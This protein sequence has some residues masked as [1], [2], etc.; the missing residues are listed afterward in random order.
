MKKRSVL[1]LFLLLLTLALFGASAAAT[2]GVVPVVGYT[3]VKSATVLTTGQ[4]VTYTLDTYHSNITDN[5][6]WVAVNVERGDQAIEMTF[7]DIT[8]S[9]YAYIYRAATVDSGI[10]GNNY[11]GFVSFKE[12][13]TWRWKADAAG[14]YYIA[15]R[16]QSSSYTA[17]IPSYLTCTLLDGDLNESNDT[18]LTATE[19]TENVST[20]YN[21]N[22]WNDVDWFK[23]TTT[24]PGEAIKLQF[25]NFDYTVANINAYLYTEAGLQAGSTSAAWSETNF[26][27]NGSYNYKANIPGNYYLK[28]QSYNNAASVTKDLKISYTT[29]A[30]DSYE[31][32][33]T[34]GT[35]TKMSYSYPMEFT[36]NGLN[37]VDW[38][39]FETSQP[40]EL[41]YLN[42]SGFDLD[43]TNHI[44]Y[45]IYEPTLDGL[46][47]SALYYV[48]NVNMTYTAAM[49]FANTGPHYIKISRYSGTAV[50]NTL[51]LTLVQ[52]TTDA[53]EPNDTWQTSTPMAENTDISFNIPSNSD[54]DW[55]KFSTTEPDQTLDLT[56]WLPSGGGAWVHLYSGADLENSGS[57]AS[58]LKYCAIYSGTSNVRWMLSDVGDYYIKVSHRQGVFEETATIKYTLIA[59]DANERNNSWSTAVT[60]NQNVTT[61]YTLPAENDYEW[62]KFTTTVPDVTLDLTTWVPSG[63]G[64]W[65]YLYSGA[66][67]QTSGSGAAS[68]KYWA[69][70]SG[71]SNMRWMLREAGEY[72]IQISARGGNIFDEKGSITYDL[73]AP[74]AHERNNSWQ[75]AK[76]MNEG[77][78]TSF[79]LPA[80][81]DSDWFKFTTAA[82]HQTV[83]INCDIP[84]GGGAWIYVYSGAD[85]QT[86]GSGA[87]SMKYWAV[88]S[89]TSTFRWMLQEAGEYYIQV[90][91]RGSYFDESASIA[92]GLINA[93]SHE[94]NNNYETATKL[95]KG[96]ALYFTLPA[97]N[98]YDYFLLGEM[99]A[100]DILQLTYGGLNPN[101]VLYTDVYVLTEGSTSLTHVKDTRI[102]ASGSGKPNTITL[103]TD[104]TYYVALEHGTPSDS[105]MWVRYAVTAADKPVEGISSI[106][107]GDSTIFQGKTLQLY[108]NITPTNATN[109][110]V[111]WSSSKTSVATVDE[112]GMVTGV[113]PGSATITATTVDGG[114]RATTT[115]TVADPV[116]VTGVTVTA[117]DVAQKGETEKNPYYLALGTNVALTATVLPETATEQAVIWSVSNDDIL[118]VN[119]YGQVYAIGS[120]SATV[121]ATTVDG[122]YTATFYVNI[123]DETY[124]VKGIALNYNAA[125]IY[126]GEGGVDLVATVTPSYATNPDVIWSSD[127]D[128][129][130]TV[131]ADGHVTPVSTGYAT[132]TV[133][134]KENN[135]VT[136]TC[137]ISVQPVRTRVTGI[138]FEAETLNLGIYGTTTLLPIIQPLDATDQSV[139]WTTNNKTVATVS[140]NGEVTGLNV[141]YA[142]ITAT[143]NDGSFSASITVKVSSTAEVGDINNDGD[144]DAG[145]A[146]LIL[147]SNVGLLTLNAA[148]CSVADVNGDN[149]ID[150]GD[151]ILIL[152][153]DA[154]LIDTFPADKQ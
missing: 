69:V 111:T 6:V 68:M 42:L 2:E 103:N 125:T 9:T 145:D 10:T 27:E 64:T 73:I 87:D 76:A 104:G 70:Y 139:T 128:A 112:N 105:T 131:D 40:N 60:L 99:T 45:H 26:S 151:A 106:T 149:E 75:T 84:T 52:G 150:A 109:Q 127:N 7:E 71:T 35:A 135:A 50:E 141:G 144:V 119:S 132:I 3:D 67:F 51:Q 108:A 36:L 93:D 12:N 61:E 101:G 34:Y 74:D 59:P 134:A 126:M 14:T 94:R 30:P 114:F 58:S 44:S 120:G 83:E 148:Q 20:Y 82:D 17:S 140:R 23:I 137:V 81:N 31:L 85:F 66:D 57:G 146:L 154:G 39:C 5:Q 79:T 41:V 33:D 37:D 43:Y 92:Y 91:V 11:A 65:V 55:F 25:S 110:S 122:S 123:P 49:T 24:V 147:R 152:R 46:S 138:S 56:T 133:A 77:V 21:L 19:L 4:K 22:G 124:P 72:Y 16:P 115:I 130:A 121:T 107:N 117:G 90:S 29:V 13:G 96:S 153:Y 129:V 100:G 98:D 116:P 97:A 102:Y 142:V 32:N 48:N 113:A 47:S 18:W 1:C 62:F 53:L 8:K 143:T 95:T 54:V 80:E 63:G 28:I 86:S 89:G 88:Y 118:A 78:T 38:F 15:L 136:N